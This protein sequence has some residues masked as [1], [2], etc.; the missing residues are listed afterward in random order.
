MQSATPNDLSIAGVVL[1]QL[2]S[3]GREKMICAI[4][5]PSDGQAQRLNAIGSTQRLETTV[6][7]SHVTYL[8]DLLELAK[9]GKPP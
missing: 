4:P 5:L 6:I 9:G 2:A 8:G 1:S 7:L 3:A